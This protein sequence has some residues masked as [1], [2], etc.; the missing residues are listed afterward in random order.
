MLDKDEFLSEFCIG[1]KLPSHLW[2]KVIRKE[3]YNEISF[4]EKL[5]YMEDF[6]LLTD[7][8]PKVGNIVY[9]KKSLY[10]YVRRSNSIT[11]SKGIDDL[12]LGFLLSLRRYNKYRTISNAA[13]PAQSVKFCKMIL[14]KTYRDNLSKNVG[15]YEDFINANISKILFDKRIDINTKKQCLIVWRGL[16][17]YYYKVKG[18]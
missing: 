14:E 18:Y 8:V 12:K 7:L 9:V 3:F 4:D 2:T 1:L 17:K 13:S 15:V 16:A 11:K 6:E 5:K 10:Y